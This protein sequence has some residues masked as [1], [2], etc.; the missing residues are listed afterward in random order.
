MPEHQ[1][2]HYLTGTDLS[3]WSNKT[4][5]WQVIGEAFLMPGNEKKPAGRLGAGILLNG[6]LIHENVERTGPTRGSLFADEAPRGPLRLQGDHG[7][8]AYGNLWIKTRSP[9]NGTEFLFQIRRSR[10]SVFGCRD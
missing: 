8:V 5:Q 9:K 1:V 10:I 7:P 6:V 4:G 2:V 3:Q